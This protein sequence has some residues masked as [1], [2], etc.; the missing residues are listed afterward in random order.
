MANLFSDHIALLHKSLDF[1]ARR[2][3]L[4][5]S[6]VANLETPGY[7]ARDLVF[8]QALGKAMKAHL[9]GPLRVTHPS[10]MDGR[11]ILPLKLVQPQV[12]ESANH[13]G[14]MDGNTVDLDKDMAKL[15]ENQIAYQALTQMIS[16]KFQTLRTVIRE[17]ER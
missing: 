2:N 14:S 13:L 9:P 11:Q 16:Y 5:A 8:E 7:K 10:H 3:A 1:R 17:G 4:L 6:N 12:I 15:S